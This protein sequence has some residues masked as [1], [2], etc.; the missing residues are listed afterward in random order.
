M[1]TKQLKIQTGV[2]KRLLKESESY[3]K[4]LETQLKRIENYVAE[5]RDEHDIRKQV[6][7]LRKQDSAQT[8][9]KA[10]NVI[11]IVILN[12]N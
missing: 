8:C 11:Y 9:S 12:G 3:A 4:E 10:D 1:S 5:G 7:C 6:C 2:V